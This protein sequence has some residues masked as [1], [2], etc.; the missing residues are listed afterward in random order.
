MQNGFWP[1]WGFNP[2]N[3]V[4]WVL[5]NNLQFLALVP[6]GLRPEKHLLK[7]EKICIFGLPHIDVKG[8]GFADLKASRPGAIG[9]VHK[10][11]TQQLVIVIAWPMENNTGARQ[12][13][14]ITLWVGR[15]LGQMC[16]LTTFVILHV[17]A[18]P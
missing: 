14:N 7:L 8:F 2:K 18:S 11:H 6:L 5:H 13:G 16:L 4:A 17:M 10:A 12:G 1:L 15:T 3:I 9:D